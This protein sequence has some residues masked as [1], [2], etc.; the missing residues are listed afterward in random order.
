MLVLYTPDE[1]SDALVLKHQSTRPSVSTALTKYSIR[2]ISDKNIAFI[3][4]NIGK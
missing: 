1:A 3:M 4:N 2:P